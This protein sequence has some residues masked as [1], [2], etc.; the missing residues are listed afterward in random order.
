MLIVHNDPSV[1]GE[2]RVPE[3]A[4]VVRHD[5]DDGDLWGVG[6]RAGGGTQPRP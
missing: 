4:L 5:G 6:A 2:L 3:P 1:P